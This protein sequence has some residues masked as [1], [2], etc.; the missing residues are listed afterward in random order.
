MTDPQTT[1][2]QGEA[3]MRAEDCACFT[4]AVGR[5][6]PGG[7][8]RAGCVR[9]L[10]LDRIL[11]SPVLDLEVQPSLSGELVLFARLPGGY[12][13]TLEMDP[14][15]Y[16]LLLEAL[17]S[18]LYDGPCAVDPEPDPA[19]L[20]PPERLQA[21]LTSLHHEMNRAYGLLQESITSSGS[22]QRGVEMLRDLDLAAG[23][24]NRP[25]ARA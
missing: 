16:L 1:D 2:P 24:A 18:P 19:G 12:R 22:R 9:A 21:L 13:A 20:A 6:R 8:V 5:V 25:A 10:E 15:A 7:E 14:V 3:P 17:L 23:A 4:L 11:T